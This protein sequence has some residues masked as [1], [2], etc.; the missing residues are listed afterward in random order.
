M[1]ELLGW[2]AW[3]KEEEI[4]H[5]LI[6]QANFLFEFLAIHPFQDG[7]GRMSRLLTN[8]L[9]IQQGYPFTRLVSHEKVIEERKNDYYLALNQ[10]QQTW[11]TD[12]ENVVP[13]IQFFL[14]TVGQQASECFKALESSHVDLSENQT[15]ILEWAQQRERAFAR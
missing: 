14:K 9:L 7:N 10:S 15:N 2:F 3:A 6:L 8:L 13:W 11:R 12:T 5:P 1:H 4:S